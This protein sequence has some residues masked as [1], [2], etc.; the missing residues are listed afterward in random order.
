VIEEEEFMAKAKKSK[1]LEAFIQSIKDEWKGT[2][3]KYPDLT[4]FALQDER[5]LG[6]IE[7]RFQDQVSVSNVRQLDYDF[8]TGLHNL[9]FEFVPSVANLATRGANA[10]LSILDGNGKV[11]ALVDPFDPVQP[12]VFVQPL[13]QE[14]EQP[15]VLDRPSASQDVT[16]SDADMHPVQRRNRAFLERLKVGGTGVGVGGVEIYSKCAYMTQT[17]K[18]YWTDYQN[19]D[20]SLPTTIL[21]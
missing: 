8:Y 13:P 1:H 18:D 17:P 5:V 2:F 21:T 14:T 12:K 19:D 9:I 6:A 20:C 11:I 15:F 7:Q 10:F 16:F 3:R 4:I